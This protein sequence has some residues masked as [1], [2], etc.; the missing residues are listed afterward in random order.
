[1]FV[2]Y[3]VAVS[4][5]AVVIGFISRRLDELPVSEAL[6]SLV[7]GV[8]LG[9][10]VLG[11]LQMPREPQPLLFELS[12]VLLAFTLMTVGLRYPKEVVRERAWSVALLLAVAMPVMALVSSALAFWLLALPLA[13]AV[14]LGSMLSPTD[15]VLASSVVTG[16][17]A[18]EALPGRARQLLSLESGANDGLAMVL[19]MAGFVL[20][21]DRPGG[22]WLLHGLA[23][24]VGGTALGAGLGTGAAVTLRHVRRLEYHHETTFPL[25]TLTFALFVLGVAE[26]L[27]V[28][29]ILAVFV[30]GIAY[31]LGITED[32]RMPQ[33]HIEEGVDRVLLLPVF[34]LFGVALPWDAWLR[35]GWPSLIFLVGVLLLRRLPVIVAIRRPLRLSFGDAVWLGWFGPI[36]IAALYYFTYMAQKGVQDTT[37]WAAGSMVIAA[38]TLSHGMTTL[39][40]RRVYEKLSHDEDA[41]SS[42]SGTEAA[43]TDS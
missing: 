35:L 11:V 22:Y 9:P 8:V 43:K 18:E 23:S 39:P 41:T 38:S 29:S 2:R 34:T 17:L 28:D 19:V 21:T 30:A 40:G 5:V 24:V 4:A 26:L 27:R 25:F 10:E 20:A 12:R 42:E 6:L 7:V 13:H 36:G 32:E 15:P 31:N 33:H 1:M 14:L 3:L 16:P 37:I